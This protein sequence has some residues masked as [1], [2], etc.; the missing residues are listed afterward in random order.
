[1]DEHNC[2]TWQIN[3]LRIIKSEELIDDEDGEIL[4]CV[5][6]F[7]LD[8]VTFVGENTV[9]ALQKRGIQQ[10]DNLPTN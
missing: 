5:Y 10:L 6:S 1:M 3:D 4:Y 2:E 9:K 8:A 7:K